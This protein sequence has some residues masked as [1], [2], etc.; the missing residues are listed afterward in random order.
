MTNCLESKCTRRQAIIGGL[1]L[2]TL[3]VGYLLRKQIKNSIFDIAFIAPCSQTNKDQDDFIATYP[4]LAYVYKALEDDIIPYYT[5]NGVLTPIVATEALKGVIYRELFDFGYSPFCIDAIS[6]GQIKSKIN[7]TFR[8]K[9][10]NASFGFTNIKPTTVN[11]DIYGK[12]PKNYQ[13]A[14]TFDTDLGHVDP[15]SLSEFLSEGGLEEQITSGLWLAG[16]IVDAYNDI[17]LESFNKYGYNDKKRG[18]ILETCYAGG[19]KW[20]EFFSEGD[21]SEWIKNTENY[22]YYDRRSSKRFD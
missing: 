8:S 13:A 4:E 2:T 18:F 12:F 19:N 3:S 17:L 16:G 15:Q 7:S 6:E 10:S 5:E 14:I 9:N 1:G 11:A 21:R 20:I 22:H